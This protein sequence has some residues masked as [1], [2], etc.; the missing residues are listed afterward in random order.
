L[1]T[2]FGCSITQTSILRRENGRR[3]NYLKALQLSAEIG[4]NWRPNF[5]WTEPPFRG[6]S[7]AETVCCIYNLGDRVAR[8]L[9]TVNLH[10]PPP[11]D[12]PP[13]AVTRDLLELFYRAHDRY[14]TPLQ[15]AGIDVLFDSRFYTIEFR[16]RQAFQA[17][18]YQATAL[19]EQLSDED[20]EVIERAIRTATSTA[21]VSGKSRVSNLLA[22]LALVIGLL[23]GPGAI[24]DFPGGVERLGEDVRHV[25]E[26]VTVGITHSVEEIVRAIDHEL[27]RSHGDPIFDEVEDYSEEASSGE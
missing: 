2:I 21:Q 27:R 20:Q 12:R 18:R 11:Y 10:W 16:L 22:G 9:A 4:D 25:T 13:P 26:V 8:D 23:Q 14:I 24:H 5:D 3:F 17:I 7:H 6:Y 19:I 15:E 1:K